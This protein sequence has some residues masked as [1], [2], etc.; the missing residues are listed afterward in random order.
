MKNTLHHLAK[1]LAFLNPIL[2]HS[3]AQQR[4]EHWVKGTHTSL[5]LIH[6]YFSLDSVTRSKLV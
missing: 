4:R 5:A 1:D 3:Y 2:G 6:E